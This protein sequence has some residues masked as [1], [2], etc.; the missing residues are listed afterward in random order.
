[1]AFSLITQFSDSQLPTPHPRDSKTPQTR[2]SSPSRR[3]N[4]LTA[5][6]QSANARLALPLAFLSC[7]SPCA[8][9]RYSR[10]RT[11]HRHPTRF[12]EVRPHLFSSG[13]H[14]CGLMAARYSPVQYTPAPAH[15]HRRHRSFRGTAPVAHFRPFAPRTTP[16]TSLKRSPSIHS[17]ASH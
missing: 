12:S 11:S 3:A 13:Y 14:P 17:R 6:R 5:T 16:F 15:S 1:M 2:R 7:L 10:S 8:T 9:D 4:A